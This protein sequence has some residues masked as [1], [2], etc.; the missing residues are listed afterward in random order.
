MSYLDLVLSIVSGSCILGHD[1]SRRVL[2]YGS[3]RAQA[4]S[5]KGSFN[6]CYKTYI[7]WLGGYK[8]LHSFKLVIKLF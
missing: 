2:C 8:T 4:R 1:G 3:P 5:Y 7:Q 6:Y